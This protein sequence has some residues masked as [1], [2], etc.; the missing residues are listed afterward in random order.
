MNRARFIQHRFK[1]CAIIA[2]LLLTGG[3]M[4]WQHGKSV[5]PTA[6]PT[7]TQPI[8]ESQFSSPKIEP[9]HDNKTTVDNS[10]PCWGGA[11]VSAFE[12]GNGFFDRKRAEQFQNAIAANEQKYVID[13][14]ARALLPTRAPKSKAFLENTPAKP[15]LICSS[16]AP[17]TNRSVRCSRRPASP[18]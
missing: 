15:S 2:G 18:C 8:S 13:L 17:S 9:T 14:R 4:I 11:L 3:L 12:D 16:K 7:Q 1:L 5:T 6:S 10:W